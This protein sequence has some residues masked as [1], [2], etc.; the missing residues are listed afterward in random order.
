MQIRQEEELDL[1]SYYRPSPTKEAT[2]SRLNQVSGTG[3]HFYSFMRSNFVRIQTAHT[4]YRIKI[5]SHV[6]FSGS[7]Q[8]KLKYMGPRWSTIF[9]PTQIYL[10]SY[11]DIPI[12]KHTHKKSNG[13]LKTI[14][15]NVYTDTYTS[16]H[17]EVSPYIA[18]TKFRIKNSEKRYFHQLFLGFTG[19]IPEVALALQFFLLNEN[20]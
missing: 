8:I 12:Y 3:K 19:E 4:L 10:R 15:Q 6:E 20:Q 13:Q 9:F 11:M 16:T 5:F 18:I 1:P 17:R 2:R 7:Q 14:H